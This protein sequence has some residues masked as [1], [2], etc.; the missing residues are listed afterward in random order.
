[1]LATK[2]VIDK[3]EKVHILKI[4]FLRFAKNYYYF[5]FIVSSKEVKIREQFLACPDWLLAF[6][7]AVYSLLSYSLASS[8]EFIMFGFDVFLRR[9]LL[10]GSELSTEEKAKVKAIIEQTI[11]QKLSVSA[12]RK[13]WHVTPDERLSV[14]ITFSRSDHLF[15]DIAPK[16][17]DNWLA[18]PRAFTVFVM[19]GHRHALI[20]PAQ[21]LRQLVE[22][23]PPKGY[24]EIKF[25]ILHRHNKYEF[26]E[27]PKVDL[28]KFYNNY[29]QLKTDVTVIE[30]MMRS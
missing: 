16:D 10:A 27:V 3:I 30:T 1:M 19:G 6:L 22:N 14:F 25:H 21:L 20:I 12:R 29:A 15:Y 5:L 2:N 28:S 18:Y 8:S 24:G 7:A 17:L 23:L 11:G 13:D 26:R 9:V 4:G